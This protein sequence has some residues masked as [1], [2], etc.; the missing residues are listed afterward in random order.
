LQQPVQRS[1]ENLWLV[2]HQAYLPSGI[3]WQWTQE[4]QYQ[5]PKFLALLL[6][7]LPQ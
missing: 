7:V 2:R 1:E 4:M 3:F 5:V 6:V